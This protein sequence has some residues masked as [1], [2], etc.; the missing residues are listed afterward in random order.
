M[1]HQ[2]GGIMTSTIRVFV[3]VEA[4]A[5]LVAASVHFG[6]LVGNLGHRR[7]A[8]AESVI[9]VVLLVTLML[10]GVHRRAARGFGLAGQALALLGTLIG[11][12]TIAIGVGPRTPADIVFHG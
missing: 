10:T 5:F 8:T 3:S 6:L 4:M 7:A 12:F 1:D 9:A 11:A 2:V